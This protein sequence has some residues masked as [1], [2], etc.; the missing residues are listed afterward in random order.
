MAKSLNA[1]QP[2]KPVRPPSSLL[3]LHRRRPSV[4]A[5]NDRHFTCMPVTY[6]AL[7]LHGMH[8][9]SHPTQCRSLLL[10]GVFD[11]ARRAC[12]IG[13]RAPASSASSECPLMHAGSGVVMKEPV[14][15]SQGS[16]SVVSISSQPNSEVDADQNT[17]HK[18]PLVRETDPLQRQRR[19]H[20]QSSQAAQRLK[21]W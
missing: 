10:H 17:P 7:R 21:S 18:P 5:A 11:V 8:Q 16:D 3:L 4:A 15:S 1:T 20:S 2:K 13:T 9:H 19:R 14:L 6:P 12:S